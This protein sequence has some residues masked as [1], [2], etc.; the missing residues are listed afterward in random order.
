MGKRKAGTLRR[1][2][3]FNH[4]AK[5]MIIAG[6]INFLGF[7]LNGFV[8][9][10]YLGVL[11]HST[12][13]FGTLSVIMEVANVVVLLASGYLA[14]RYGRK[15]MLI[16][17]GILSTIGMGMFAFFETI[18]AFIIASILLGASSGFWGPAFNALLTVK[19]KPKRRK[20]LFSLNAIIGHTGSGIITLIG[21]FIPLFFIT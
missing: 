7:A 4:D 12:V 17:S 10:L 15:R 9:I 21:G 5:L 13:L 2:K 14:D 18:P 20:Y 19:T 6:L 3:G 8:L 11:G 1:Y 16:I